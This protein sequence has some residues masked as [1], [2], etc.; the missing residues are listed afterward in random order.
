MIGS[1]SQ[2]YSAFNHVLNDFSLIINQFESLSSLSA[3]LTRLNLFLDK[4][5]QNGW[6]DTHFHAKSS[7]IDHFIQLKVNRNN[8]PN[9]IVSNN[10]ILKCSNLTVMIPDRSRTLIGDISMISTDLNHK[11]SH[12]INVV[13][14]QYDHVLIV[15]PSGSG[16]SSFIRAISGLWKIGSGLI[17]W[18]IPTIS[19]NYSMSSSLSSISSSNANSVFTTNDIFFLPQKPYNFLGTIRD[20][21]IYP[22]LSHY[23]TNRTSTPAILFNSTENDEYFFNILKSVKLGMFY[24]TKLAEYFIVY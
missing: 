24:S 9:N 12:G 16:K 2:S 7:S 14:N 17:E 11:I 20:Q 19:S 6:E 5:N 3:G 18:N 21:I 4:I 1:I 22:S 13:I 8:N 23:T 10:E 15:G